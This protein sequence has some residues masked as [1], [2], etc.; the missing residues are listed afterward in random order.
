VNSYSKLLVVSYTKLSPLK[1]IEIKSPPL[2]E[3]LHDLG[4]SFGTKCTKNY[5][6][7][8]VKIPIAD[9]ILLRN[10]E[11]RSINRAVK[12]IELELENLECVH[13]LANRVGLNQNKLQDGFHALYALSVNR[14]IQKERLKLAIT[15]LKTTTI[16]MVEI[17]ERLGLNSQSHFSKIFRD[18][19]NITPSH[20]RKMHQEK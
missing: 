14:Y 19:Y 12:I 18:Q 17:R 6:G 15:L 10:S 8:L 7:L 5:D 1:S 3:V 16:S 20:Y 9:K 2:T 4:V 11:V 13:S